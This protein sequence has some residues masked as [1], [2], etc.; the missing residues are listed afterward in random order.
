MK[1]NSLSVQNMKSNDEITKIKIDNK[2]ITSRIIKYTKPNINDEE[3]EYFL[4]TSLRKTSIDELSDL[5]WR[6][7]S[8][9]TDFRKC[10]YD[11]MYDKIR[12]KTE[13][14][15]NFDVRIINFVNILASLIENI[16]RSD[17]KKT[18]VNSKNAIDITITKLLHLPVGQ[19]EN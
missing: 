9:E 7:W 17:D 18:K 10:K 3:N 13:K 12:S 5:Y 19:K 6:R 15:V 2:T 11:I 8:V 16:K 1:S 14:Q 4:L